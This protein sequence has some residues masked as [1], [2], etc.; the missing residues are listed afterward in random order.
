LLLL[1]IYCE[2]DDGVKNQNVHAEDDTIFLQALLGLFTAAPQ[3]LILLARKILDQSGKF[4]AVR[5]KSLWY[6]GGIIEGHTN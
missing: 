3:R 5:T 4:S 6:C 1:K 2:F